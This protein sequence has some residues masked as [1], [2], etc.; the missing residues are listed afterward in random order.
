[1][2]LLQNEYQDTYKQVLTVMSPAA[3][4]KAA[5]AAVRCALQ[6]CESINVQQKGKRV[7]G[8]R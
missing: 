6:C 8:T 3:G 1:M 7:I 5:K 2:I 4:L